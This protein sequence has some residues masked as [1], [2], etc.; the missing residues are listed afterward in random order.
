ML[1][2][3]YSAANDCIIFLFLGIELV[4]S[5]HDWHTGFALWSLLFCLFYRFIGQRGAAAGLLCLLF[6]YVHVDLMVY[7]TVEVGPCRAP[8][9]ERNDRCINIMYCYI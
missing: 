5:V 9:K 2:S 8:C 4:T 7:V 3:D 6:T 1:L